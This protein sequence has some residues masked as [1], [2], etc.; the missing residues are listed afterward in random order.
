MTFARAIWGT[1][2]MC[3]RDACATKTISFVVQASR[4]HGAG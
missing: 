2:G 4:L 1:Q 3:R